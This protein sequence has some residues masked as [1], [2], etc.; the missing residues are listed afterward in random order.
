MHSAVTGYWPFASAALVN[1]EYY[2]RDYLQTIVCIYMYR[3]S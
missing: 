1:C 3:V 2:F